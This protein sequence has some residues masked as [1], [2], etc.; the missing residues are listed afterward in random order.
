MGE[1]GE[2][3][4]LG[5][6]GVGEVPAVGGLQVLQGGHARTVRQRC[7]AQLLVALP[8][9]PQLIAR[10]QDPDVGSLPGPPRVSISRGL[11]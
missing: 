1:G 11:Y 8:A 3:S 6:A 2:G 9:A 4:E 5:E 7:I 10:S